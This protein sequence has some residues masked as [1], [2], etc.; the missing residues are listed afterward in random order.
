MLNFLINLKK[1][2]KH[3]HYLINLSVYDLIC[4]KSTTK[5]LEFVQL[6][7]KYIC[8]LVGKISLCFKQYL[9]K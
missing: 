4:F 6:L 5:Q 9:D 2:D 3:K 7:N 1:F 8:E